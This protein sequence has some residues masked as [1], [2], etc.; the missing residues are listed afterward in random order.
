MAAVALSSDNITQIGLIVI[1]ALVVIGAILSFVI[2]A[3]VARIVILVLV[4]GLAVVVWQQRTHLKDKF[5]KCEL[6][7]T[8]FGVHFDAPDSVVQHCQKRLQSPHA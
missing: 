4:V 7:A 8:F 5:D 1:V 6:Q 3:L 2:T